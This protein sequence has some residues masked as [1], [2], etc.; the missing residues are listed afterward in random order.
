MNNAQFYH[1][2]EVKNPLLY[3]AL[4]NHRTHRGIRLDLEK[5]P[6][7]KAM[8]LD[9]RPFGRVIKSV[10]GGVSEWLL[11]KGFTEV[12][13]KR[14]IFWVLPD[15]GVA[16]R[17]VRERW[18]KTLEYSPEY[19][20]MA[21]INPDTGEQTTTL[22]LLKLS[23][24]MKMLAP[25]TIA[26]VGSKSES[27]MT[28]FVADTLLVDEMD[29]CNLKNL[30]MAPDR[31]GFAKD[32]HDW[33]ISNP[34]ITAYGID[35]EYA[36]SAKGRW[37]IRCEHCGRYFYPDPFQVL[38]RQVDDSHFIIRDN[39]YDEESAGDARIICPRC[40]KP[41][42]RYGEGAWDEEYPTRPVAGYQFSRIFTS[43]TPL[44][45]IINN[46]DKGLLDPVK[47]M[48]C[49][50][51]DF[52]LA[53]DAPGARVTRDML[54]NAKKDYALHVPSSKCIMGAD[55]GAVIN[56][57]IASL[58]PLEGRYG[59][60]VVYAGTV[61]EEQDIYDLYDRY[62]CIAGIVDAMPEERMSRRMT[63]RRRGLF[64]AFYNRGKA[65]RVDKE[66]KIV[67]INRTSAMDG[68]KEGIQLGTIELPWDI[69]TVPDFFN[70][71]MAPT[72]LYDSDREEFVWNEGSKADH[73]FHSLVYLNITRALVLSSM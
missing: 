60:R 70:Q 67:T 21:T 42:N 9:R 23:M 37:Y 44:R 26:F 33:R 15:I 35:E 53:Y 51:A 64:R 29:Q 43:N 2:L 47:M 41:V 17:F 39:E 16:S 30:A 62:H 22:S 27:S 50:N 49:Y 59:M 38:L 66:K 19:V 46:F 68:V 55:I 40:H 52:G 25:G 54:L 20:K 58:F 31:Y 4:R 10:Q 34:T 63:R 73:Y 32:P 28:E 69:E 7:M 61:R 3:N 13:Q 24:G 65:D 72:R 1:E 5:F 36:A 11:C 8:Y 18:N 14:N 12:K 45:T 6:A 56:V 57:V 71:M 48:R